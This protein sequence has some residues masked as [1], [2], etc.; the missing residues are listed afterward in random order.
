MRACSGQSITGCH[1]DP[2][3]GTRSCHRTWCPGQEWLADSLLALQRHAVTD[4]L[5]LEM[6]KILADEHVNDPEV[7]HQAD[8]QRALGLGYDEY[9]K[10]TRESIRP[11]VD[12]ILDDAR[13]RSEQQQNE[14]IR[15]LQALQ[16]VLRIDKT[17]MTA[18][19]PD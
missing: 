2:R 1:P 8:L 13:G 16:T 3:C 19:W 6:T 14:I 12:Q 15:R 11:V 10:L 5:R 4:L 9:L 18:I 17:T 7:M